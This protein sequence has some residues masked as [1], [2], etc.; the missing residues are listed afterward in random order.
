MSRKISPLAQRALGLRC[1]DHNSSSVTRA[2]R[3]F[4]N[5]GDAR[6]AWAKRWSDLIVAHANDLGGAETLSEAQISIC[7]RAA[8]IEVEL[9]SLE[10][11]MSASQSID[12]AVYARLTG[13]LCRLFELVGIKGRAK[14]DPMSELV[15]L[16]ADIL[17]LSAELRPPADAAPA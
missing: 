10:G 1:V 4:V 9:E 2:K 8:A 11:K 14:L 6:S 5:L 7:R 13:V 3:M 16:F 17:R 15:N 12:I